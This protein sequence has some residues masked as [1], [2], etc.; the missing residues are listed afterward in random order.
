MSNHREDCNIDTWQISR[1]ID[2]CRPV[3]DGKFKISV[4]DFQRGLVWNNK[5]QRGLIDSINEGYPLGSLLLYEGSEIDGKRQFSIVDGLQRTHAI[6]SFVANP[7]HYFASEDVDEKLVSTIDK[8]F[9]IPE[10]GSHNRVRKSIETWVKSCNGF[11]ATEGWGVSDLTQHLLEDLLGL[12]RKSTEYHLALGRIISNN[13]VSNIMKDF[14]ENVQNAADIKDVRL[15]VIL[16]SGERSK[17]PR[18]FE[19]LNSQGV[20]L[21]RYD[22]FSASWLEFKTTIRNDKIRAAIYKKYAALVEEG[23]TSEALNSLD[24]ERD[25]SKHQYSL[26]EFLFGFGQFLSL[27]FPNLFGQVKEDAPNSY[28]FN[29]VTA[30]VGMRLNKMSGL[31]AFLIDSEI[32][33]NDLCE[34]IIECA[35]WV[36]DCLNSI[37]SVNQRKQQPVIFHAELQIISFIATVF[38]SKYDERTVEDKQDWKSI[39]SELASN[40]RMY[41]LYDIVRQYW[42][43]SG[44]SKLYDDVLNQRYKRKPPTS[45]YWIQTLN[46][47]FGETQ[48]SMQH[49]R[50]YV[51]MNSPEI[52]FLK[53]IY[54]QKFTVFQ[55]ASEFHV[56]HVIPNKDLAS[57]AKLDTVGWP[58]NCVAN[59]ALLEKKQNQRKGGRTFVDYWN[60]RRANNAIDDSEME[61]NISNDEAK[62]L[63][64]REIVPED[65]KNL[66]KQRY[67]QFLKERFER[68]REDFI[69]LWADHFSAE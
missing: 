32:E 66:D 47:W 41:F 37:L 17:L 2:A 8:E 4:P 5:K 25:N 60:S 15:S 46:S 36:E 54:V 7:N 23:F 34:Q 53:Y 9:Q 50:R 48:I 61:E 63:C 33:L 16:Y 1:L 58:I 27:E 64:S 44:D 13:S 38:A 29:L 43:G 52:L 40:F 3:P 59:L 22:I 19:L 6:R 26:Y 56:E 69:E 20:T 14:L 30:C 10:L 42:R 21:S 39:S 24:D 49:K 11:A 35:S 68:L 67:E 65:T 51:R 62:L 45:E 12:D 31:E 55:N 18:I 28:G 57:R